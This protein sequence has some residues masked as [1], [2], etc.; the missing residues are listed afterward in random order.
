L[1]VAFS[2]DSSYAIYHG[3]VKYSTQDLVIFVFTMRMFAT[4]ICQSFVLN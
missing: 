2:V 4:W 3:P 1:E